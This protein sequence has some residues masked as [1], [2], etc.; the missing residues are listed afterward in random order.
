MGDAPDM[1]FIT[2]DLIETIFR[3]LEQQRANLEHWPYTLEQ[4][5]KDREISDRL[6]QACDQLP[7]P[8]SNAMKSSQVDCNHAVIDFATAPAPMPET[9][10]A[11]FR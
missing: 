9:I 5:A 10:Y 1:D 11:G 7:S 8:R 6:R 2:E 4:L 3:L